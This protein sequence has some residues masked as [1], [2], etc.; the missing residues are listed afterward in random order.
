MANE[1]P[2]IEPKIITI[3]RGRPSFYK[4]D[5]PR[6]RT[7]KFGKEIKVRANG[8][9]V[10]PNYTMTW[11]LD[12]SEAQAAATIAEIKAEGARQL[13]IYHNGRENWPKD[14]LQ[15]G[16][17]GVLKCFGNGNDLP[18]V[19]AGYKDMFFIKVA[20]STRPIVGDRSG[21]AVQFVPE[22]GM[23]HY[24]GKDGPTEEKAD[25][26]KIPYGGAF[27]RGRISLYIYDNE[28]HGLNANFRSVQF[29]EPGEAFGGGGARRNVA[30]ELDQM[31]GDKEFVSQGESQA[32]R[33]P[34]G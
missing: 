20:D 32:E 11:L 7:D 26:A 21:R 12:P 17:K 8:T 13:D 16:T 10:K 4:A 1:R 28:A 24:V 33:D 27:C 23:W 9:P 18:K 15:T 30:E 29:L 2:K 25:P 14:N 22:D 6:F 31:A 3:H 34:W 19:Y 5:V